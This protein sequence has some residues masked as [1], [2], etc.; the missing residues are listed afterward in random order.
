MEKTELVLRPVGFIGRQRYE[1]LFEVCQVRF[2]GALGGGP[3]DGELRG[4]GRRW[5]TILSSVGGVGN[6]PGPDH[7]DP[8]SPEPGGL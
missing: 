6:G 1:E 3:P 7:H 2:V 4:V 5:S 8:G